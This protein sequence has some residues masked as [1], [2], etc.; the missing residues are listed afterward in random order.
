[1]KRVKK[2]KP[3]S[4]FYLSLIYSVLQKN[5]EQAVQKL[6]EKSDDVIVGEV[7]STFWASS[8]DNVSIPVVHF[9]TV[10]QDSHKA[11]M[12]CRMS[13]SECAFLIWTIL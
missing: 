13:A 9:I 8:S 3:L 6:V 7:V 4:Y 1:M 5:T 2:I 10:T 12:A 11:R